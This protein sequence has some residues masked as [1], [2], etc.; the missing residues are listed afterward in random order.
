MWNAIFGFKPKGSKTVQ[1]TCKDILIVEMFCFYNS[2]YII[3]EIVCW[4]SNSGSGAHHGKMLL[5]TNLAW[6]SD[7]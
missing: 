3:R 4:A 1:K 6:I 5:V 2:K 7:Y